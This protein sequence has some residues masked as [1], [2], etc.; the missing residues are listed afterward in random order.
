MPSMTMTSSV[1]FFSASKNSGVNMLPSRAISAMS[2]RFA[3]RNSAISG[4]R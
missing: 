2:T 4:S 3:P 1:A